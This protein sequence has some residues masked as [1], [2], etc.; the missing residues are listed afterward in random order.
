[1]SSPTPPTITSPSVPDLAEV[2]AWIEKMIKALRFVELVVAIVALIGR[3]REI[4]LE[5]TQQI[6]NFRRARPRSETLRRL[7]AQHVFPFM[8]EVPRRSKPD[9][10]KASRKG[11]HPGRAALPAHLLRVPVL[12]AVPPEDRMCPLCGR[13]MTT[14][15]HNVCETLEIQPARVYVLERKDERVACPYDDTIVSA[16]TP[17]QIVE[18]GKLGDTL[19]VEAVADKFIEHQPTERQ[20]RRLSRGAG[21]DVPPQ[22]LG[23]S[24]AAAIDLVSP[25]AREIRSETRARALLATDATGLPVLD[26]DHPHGIR[27]GTMWCWIGDNKWVTF[28]YTPIGDAKSVKDFLGEDLCRTVQCDGTNLLTFLERAGGKRPGC[29]SH[30]RRGLVACARAGDA[31][32]I[33]PLRM[34]R[35]LFAVE[36]LSAMHGETAEARLRRRREDS[37]PTI[38]ELRAWI[39]DN[40]ALIPPKTPLGKAIGYLHRQ[41]KRLVLFLTDGRIELTNNRVERELRALV[42]GRKNWLFA[43]GDLGGERTAT[44]LTIFGT[45]IAHGI[46]PRAYLHVVTKLIVNGWPNARLREL[47]PDRIGEL[48]AELRLPPRDARPLPALPAPS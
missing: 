42:L 12:N 14:V 37:A 23:R 30:G 43:Y 9:K 13:M 5:L 46:N 32:A 7:E 1:M 8:I 35:R 34:I 24:M 25:I 36:R 2:R 19:I 40:R 28:F 33:V 10:S 29:W 21:V 3:M 11:K 27:N 48:H 16:K 17:P 31:L 47:L 44:I 18:R 6:V 22:T 26:E 4:N 38:A 15:G 39:D 41:W 20:S 45:C